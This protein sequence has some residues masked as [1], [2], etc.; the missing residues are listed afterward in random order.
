M[1]FFKLNGAAAAPSRNRPGAKPAPAKKAAPRRATGFAPAG[2]LAGS[3]AFAGA[4]SAEAPDETN[5]ARF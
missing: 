2:G 3:L 5:F 4:A 1:A